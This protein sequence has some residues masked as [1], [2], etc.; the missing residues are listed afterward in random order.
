MFILMKRPESHAH[1]QVPEPCPDYPATPNGPCHSG[2]PGIGGGLP[3][4]PI[5]MVSESGQVG[6]LVGD[7]LLELNARQSDFRFEPFI[8]SPKRRHL[9]FIEGHYQL[10]FFESPRWSWH[11]VDHLATEPLLLDRELY[12]ALAKAGRDQSFFEPISERRIVAMLGYHY[13]FADQVT[14]EEAL[15]QRFDIELSHSHRRNLEL[16]LADR[17]SVAEVA[18]VSE[19]Y[20][21][22]FLQRQPGLRDRL[23]V[24]DTPD[25][26]YRMRVLL[27]PDASIGLPTLTALLAALD[28]A[29]VYDDLVARYGLTLP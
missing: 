2:N 22:L 9:D 24:S 29:G 26:T 20:L 10:I 11:D 5:A 23:L 14:D 18:V 15:R 12:V 8:T 28:D 3:L 19:S 27:R 16:I 6:G 25:Q 13:G 21:Q 7:L 4:P 17:P 1:H